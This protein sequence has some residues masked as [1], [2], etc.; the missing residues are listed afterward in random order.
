MID[1]L[2]FKEFGNRVKYWVTLNEPNYYSIF[3]YAYGTYSPGRCSE[4]IN[5]CTAGNSATEPY[6]VGHNLLLAHASAVRLYKQR[7]QAWQKGVI[8]MTTS[9][10][11][12]IP[13]DNTTADCEAASR[14]YDF[15]A[16]WFLEPITYGDYPKT[17]RSIVGSRLPNFTEEQSQILKHSYDYFGLNYYTTSYAA[18][19]T[20]STSTTELSYTTDSH[21]TLTRKPN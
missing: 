17:M 21:V 3:G 4:Y 20:S 19:D 1:Y 10:N 13:L 6:Q 18:N 11:W 8:G 16:G 12:P 14:A 7:Y 2:C 5:N 9:S 15:M